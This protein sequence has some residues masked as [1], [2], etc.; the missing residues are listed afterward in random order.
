MKEAGLEPERLEMF[1][2]GASNADLFAKACD[3]MAERARKLGPNPLRKER[4]TLP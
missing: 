2:M 3:Q 4:V 1:N